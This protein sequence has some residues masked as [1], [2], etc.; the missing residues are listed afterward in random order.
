[1]NRNAAN[2]V[3]EIPGGDTLSTH[4]GTSAEPTHTTRGWMRRNPWLVAFLASI[5]IG[6]WTLLGTRE[7]DPEFQPLIAT[8]ELGDIEQLVTA[9]GS[10][11]PSEFVDVGAQVSGQ[12]DRLHVQ[13]GDRVSTGDLL[14]EIDA[15]VQI[16]RVKASRAS[17]QGDEAQLSS[18]QAALTLAQASEA[19]QR[20]LMNDN[21]T[22]QEGFDKATNELARAKSELAHLQSKIERSQAGLA[23]DEAQLGYSRIY[24]P[25]SGTV[26]A[27]NLTEGQTLNATQRVPTILR[28]ASLGTMTVEAEVSEADVSKLHEGTSVYFTTLGGGERRWYSEVRQIQPTPTIVN[29]VVSYPVLF[30]ADN[31]D[32]ALLPGMT[33]QIFFVTAAARSVLKIPIA[34]LTRDA[35]ANSASVELIGEDGSRQTRS[36][37]VGLSNRISAEVLSGLRAGDKVV[38]GIKEDRLPPV[39]RTRGPFR[40]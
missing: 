1:M 22:T 39:R 24:A 26:V 17:L 12:L 23:S 21:L 29:N 2:S 18:R 20:Q 27:I 8:I 11:Q 4:S 34:A 31:T 14:A 19:R 5:L 7:G 9:A 16:N 10:L 36:I 25:M 28:I 35:Q 38:A 30:D 3:G 33:A 37:Q 13:I 6:G 40:N 15:R 32:S